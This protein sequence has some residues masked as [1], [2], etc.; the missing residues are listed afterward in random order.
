M[1]CS[2]YLL[3]GT[4]SSLSWANKGFVYAVLDYLGTNIHVFGTHMQNDGKRCRRGQGA[5]V[6]AGNLDDMRAYID[7]RKI[8]AEELVIIAGDFNINDDSLEYSASLL[9]RLDV[10]S[11]DTYVGYGYSFDPKEVKEK[12]GNQCDR[13]H[14]F[15]F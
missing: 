1:F 11:A 8:P 2:N 4:P 5:Q 6:R 12:T 7:D 9:S 10:Q 15:F 13:V 14:F 3:C